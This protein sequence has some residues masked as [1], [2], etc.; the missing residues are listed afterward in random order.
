MSFQPWSMEQVA[1]RIAAAL[2]DGAYVNL[3]IGLPQ[4]VANYLPP[5]REVVYHAEHGLLGIGPEAKPEEADPDYTDA[6]ANV[7]TLV[8]GASVFNHDI[9]FAMIRGG[10]IDITVLGAYQVSER[11][12][13]ANWAIA[14]QSPPPGVGGAMDLAVGAK[15]VFVMMRHQDKRG[16]PKIVKEC[17]YPLT[18][19]RCVNRIFTDLA[20]IEVTP[21]GLL[22]VDMPPGLTLEELQA[23]TEPGL[24]M[25]AEVR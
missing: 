9:S 20:V 6:G 22:V 16:A 17:T 21:D 23:V 18:A 1:E 7:I 4:T 10:H 19:E 2:W 5:D 25:A 13:L 11:G 8:P 14:G 3:G 24:R 15:N 12:D